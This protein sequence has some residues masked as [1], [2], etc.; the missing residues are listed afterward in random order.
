[1]TRID[2][3]WVVFDHVVFPANH[4]FER[5]FLIHNRDGMDHAAVDDG[6]FGR[7]FLNFDNAAGDVGDGLCKGDRGGVTENVT[8]AA[9]E[10]RPR[11]SVLTFV[12]KGRAD[13]GKYFL[14]RLFA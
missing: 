7:V 10:Q 2:G 9:A 1:M 13:F 12:M 8:T 6:K 14:R 5:V 4:A 11:V 3:V